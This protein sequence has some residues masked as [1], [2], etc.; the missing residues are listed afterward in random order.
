MSRII[1]ILIFVLLSSCQKKESE[2][3][4]EKNVMTNIFPNLIDSIYSDYRTMKIPSKPFME[5]GISDSL[6]NEKIKEY[7]IFLADREKRINKI[8]NDTSRVVLAI[9]DTISKIIDKSE[10]KIDISKLKKSDKYIFKYYSDFPRD[11]KIW[12]AKYSF[13]FGG[14]IS[15]S[16]IKFNENKDLGQLSVGVSYYDKDAQGFD[17]Y[18]KKDKNDKWIIKKVIVTWIS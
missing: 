7:K 3:D 16:R 17:V 10:Y 2:L 15:F 13:Y 6:K 1:V 18:I 12:S 5:N 14:I 8:K 9:Y 4:Y 11:R